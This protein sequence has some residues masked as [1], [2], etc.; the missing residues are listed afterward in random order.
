[1]SAFAILYVRVGAV[2][3][4]QEERGISH[5]TEHAALLGT[6]KFSSKLA[7][8][9]E[10]QK[11]GAN[12][13]GSA[14]RFATD[15][16]V[17]LPYTN[18]KEGIN[19]LY[20]LT[21]NPLLE[22]EQISKEKDVVLSE[23]NDFWHNPERKFWHEVWRKRFK[24][25]E[26]PYSYRAMGIPETIKNFD[27]NLVLSWRKKYYHPNNMILSLA[28]NFEAGRVLVNSRWKWSTH[29]RMVWATHG[30]LDVSHA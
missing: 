24:Q 30:R 2:Y 8:S 4:R 13:D 11:L 18:L 20:E 28:G 27:K 9:Y 7:L 29:G 12:F 26:H 1:M 25:K 23:F 19:F 14:D 6:K 10:A 15:Y 5:F 21:F 3:E 17:R 22:E 16:W